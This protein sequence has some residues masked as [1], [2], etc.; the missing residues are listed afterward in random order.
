M[1]RVARC[2]IMNTKIGTCVDGENDKPE[3]RR[4]YHNRK[5]S[6]HKFAWFRMD[7]T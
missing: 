1:S 4:L 6:L 7:M 5:I 2:E 3:N